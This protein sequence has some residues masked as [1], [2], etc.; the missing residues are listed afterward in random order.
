[1]LGRSLLDGAIPS[2][3]RDHARANAERVP[4]NTMAYADE[5]APNA[6]D[7][8]PLPWQSRLGEPQ[9]RLRVDSGA[10]WRL[11]SRRLRSSRWWWLPAWCSTS[12]RPPGGPPPGGWVPPPGSP[13][14]GGGGSGPGGYGPP[15]FTSAW[16]RWR[17][18]PRWLGSRFT[19]AWRGVVLGRAGYGPPGSPPPW[20]GWRS[21]PR[22]LGSRFTST[23]RGWSWAGRVWSSRF[24]SAWRGWRSAPRW[25]ESSGF[26]SAWRGSRFTSA[27]RGV[28]LRRV[29]MVLRRPPVATHPVR[30]VRPVR[31][32]AAMVH[33]AA[34]TA[35]REATAHLVVV[36]VR[37]VMVR[38]AG[39]RSAAASHPPPYH[40]G[41]PPPGRPGFEAS[42]AIAFGW[43]AV[44]KDFAGVALPIAVAGFV[45]ALPERCHWR[46][47][48]RRGRRARG[49]RLGRS[50]R[51]RV[52][53]R[54][55]LIA[56]LSG[57]DR[58]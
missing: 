26:A 16:R 56:Q 4:L 53:Q 57:F 19:S 1:M 27:W 30:P 42:E 5:S 36:M 10:E 23:W 35:R 33:P 25:L 28:V 17:S 12:G 15:R 22:W 50:H 38:P 21:A 2:Q 39:H 9:T 14:P 8:N 3:L 11:S 37:P 41:A 29:G 32:E 48:R 45:S 54:R 13:P 52:D 6:V 44:T 31:P 51:A 7:G 47:S 20:R 40:P 46:D 18:A 43:A 34:V 55:W 49:I 24:T 58:R